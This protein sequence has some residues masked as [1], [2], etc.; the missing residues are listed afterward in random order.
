MALGLEIISYPRSLEVAD[1]FFLFRFLDF[2]I[3]NP[4]PSGLVSFSLSGLKVG[5]YK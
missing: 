4:R 3:R 2:E 1:L 5:V